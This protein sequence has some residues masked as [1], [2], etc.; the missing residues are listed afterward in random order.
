MLDLV[1]KGGTVV[2][3]SGRGIWD[4]GIS[5]GEIVAVA[6]PQTLPIEASRIIHADGML[7]V[8]G[9]VEPHAHAAS[10]VRPGIPQTVPGI[11]NA[12][13]AVHSLGAIW[14]GTT[15][16]VDFAPVPNDGDIVGGVHEY[17][18]SWKGNAY[19]DYST[20]CVYSSQNT[21]DSIARYRELVDAGLPSV[22]IF[23]TIQ[24][25]QKVESH[26]VWW[27]KWI[28]AV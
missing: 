6:L 28:W 11:D 23:T 9:G 27:Q 10:N 17:I 26:I 2:T 1:I 16:I 12:G 24:N 21:P 22:K 8:P 18:S 25:R 13:P 20:H 4:V 15:T 7:V 5:K 3:P 14:G 19:T